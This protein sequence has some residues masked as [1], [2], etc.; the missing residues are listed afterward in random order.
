[1]PAVKL[2]YWKLILFSCRGDTYRT[3]N[4]GEI[5]NSQASAARLEAHAD[6]TE[7]RIAYLDAKPI[8]QPNNLK[9][10]IKALVD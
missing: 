9:L 7:T 4:N 8:L 5:I 3:H 10:M 1:M 6:K 2:I